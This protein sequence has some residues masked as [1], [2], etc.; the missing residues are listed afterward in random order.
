MTAE[1][2]RANSYAVKNFQKISEQP[3][4]D[5]PRSREVDESDGK[6]WL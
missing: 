2:L 1:N 5:F 6:V 4:S 3:A